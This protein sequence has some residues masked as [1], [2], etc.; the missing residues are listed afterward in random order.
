VDFGGA[1]Q[2]F[3][4]IGDVPGSATVKILTAS[5]PSYTGPA[6]ASDITNG[7]ETISGTAS[8]QDSTLANWTTALSPNTVI[9]AQ[10]LSPTGFTWLQG[11]LAIAAN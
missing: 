7:G 2:Q 4:A 8:K 11:E 3:V 9:C 1:I 6:S 5:L 10:L